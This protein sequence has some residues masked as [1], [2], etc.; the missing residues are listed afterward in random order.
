MAYSTVTYDNMKFNETW[1][2][3][4]PFLEGVILEITKKKM[5]L[6]RQSFTRH[7]GVKDPSSLAWIVIL[8]ISGIWSIL[9]MLREAW[10]AVLGI[11]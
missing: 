1:T 6:W 5:A 7:G 2:S 11:G 8:G 3:D 4:W 10:E 9:W